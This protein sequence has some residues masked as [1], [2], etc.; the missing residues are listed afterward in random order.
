MPYVPKAGEEVRD[1]K[2]MLQNVRPLLDPHIEALADEIIKAAKEYGYDGA[3]AG[4]VNYSVTRIFCR[5]LISLFGRLRYWHSPIVRGT[6]QDIGDEFYRRVMIPY[7]EVQI[8]KNG[9]VPEYQTLIKGI[10]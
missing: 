2:Q 10:K 9:G 1:D 4:L 5:I 3:F 6:C 7:E 8:V